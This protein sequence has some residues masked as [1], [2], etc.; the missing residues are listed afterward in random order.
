[1]ANLVPLTELSREEMEDKE[2]EE[3]KPEQEKTEWLGIDICAS[4]FVWV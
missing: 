3:E 2:Q 4:D 1:M